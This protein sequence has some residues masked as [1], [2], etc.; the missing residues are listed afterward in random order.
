MSKYIKYSIIAGLITF[1]LCLFVLLAINSPSPYIGS[2]VVGFV[3]F[4]ISFY[5]FFGRE[6]EK[7]KLM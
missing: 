7:Q 5:H 2:L 3:I 6:K 4:E 1:A